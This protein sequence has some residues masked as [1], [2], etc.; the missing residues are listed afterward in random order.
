MS[1]ES[2]RRRN[3][4]RSARRRARTAAKKYGDGPDPIFRHCPACGASPRTPCHLDHDARM[5]GNY[6]DAR[7]E[8]ARQLA[9]ATPA[10]R[11]HRNASMARPPR[12][13]RDD[14]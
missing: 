3:A 13:R 11:T 1:R 2:N 10:A 7:H 14:V 6:H 9:G 5:D 4:R 12:L 8:A